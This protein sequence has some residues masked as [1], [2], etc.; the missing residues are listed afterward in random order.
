MVTLAMFFLPV[1]PWHVANIPMRLMVISIYMTFS[2]YVLR[3]VFIS[4]LMILHNCIWSPS[5]HMFPSK[6]YFSEKKVQVHAFLFSSVLLLQLVYL[7]GVIV[8]ICVVV[9]SVQY[10]LLTSLLPH[11]EIDWCWLWTTA[12]GSS[13]RK[14]RGQ[15]YHSSHDSGC[16][17]LSKYNHCI[18]LYYN[19]WR[20]SIY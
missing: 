12:L 18:L 20:L 16:S 13:Y 17:S 11:I 10:S 15:G 8:L 19:M 4:E 2:Q 9:T 14:L 5:Y 6:L 7:Q 1:T 3:D